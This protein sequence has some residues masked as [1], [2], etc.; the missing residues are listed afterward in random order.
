MDRNKLYKLAFFDIDGTLSVPQYDF[1]SVIESEKG[2]LEVY[3]EFKDFVGGNLL[4]GCEESKWVDFNILN[5]NSYANCR[6]PVTIVN[7]VKKL[8]EKGTVVF[9]LTEEHFSF[10]LNNKAKWVHEKYKLPLEN[11]VWVDDK[12]KKV[13]MI[14][15]ICRLKGIKDLSDVLMVDDTF[16]IL[17]K[18]SEKGISTAH[19]SE[20]VV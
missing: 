15:R 7:F 10:A 14:C 11:V 6:A 9:A 12:E 19:I 8:R 5:S 4:N 16:S 1:A 2:N 17:L 13:D 18:A 3:Q 20:F